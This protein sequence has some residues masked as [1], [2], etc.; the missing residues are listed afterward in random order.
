MFWRNY[1]RR[2]QADREWREEMEAH[3]EMAADTFLAQGMSTEE[4]RSAA[5]KQAGNLMARREEIYQMNG[6]RWLDTLSG[7]LRYALRG[8]RRQRAFTATALLTLALGIGA[9][10]AIFGVI[11]SILIRPLAYP[12]AEALVGVWHTAPGLQGLGGSIECTPSMYFTYREENRT[13][14][15]FGV[16]SSNGASVTGIAEPELPRALFVTYGVL[17][18][19]GVNP[20]LGRWFSQADDT[21]GSPDAVILTYGYWQRRF[22]G[23]KSIIGRALT[24]NSK[25]HTVIGVMPR[26]FRFGRDPELI[27]PQRFERAKVFLGDFS[28]QGIAR[29]KPG[30]TIAQANADQARMLGVWLNAWPPTPGFPLSLFQNAHVGP[31]IQPLKQEIVGDVGATLWVVMGTLFLVLLIACANVA[32][33]LLVRGESRQQ[34][35][36]IRAALGAGWRRI[37][38][39]ML[40]ESLTLGLIGGALGL[41]LAYAALRVLV[42]KGPATLPRLAEIGIDPLVFAFALGASLFSGVLFGVIPVFKYAGPRVA[43]ALRGVGRTFSQGRERHRARNLLVVV[44]V[45]FALVLL[46][47]SGLM[48][49][50]FQ[51]LRTVR[52]GFTHPEEIQILHSFAPQA[53]ANE[54]ERVMRMYQEIRDK[55]AAIPGV[56]SVALA[57]AAPLE[58]F[59]SP[60]NPIYAEDKP[61]ASG[62]L[63]PVRRFRM[64]A[65][66]FFK[67]MGTR[68][69]AGRDFTWTDLYEKRYVA[70]VS[71]NLAREVWGDPRA[72]LG[73]RIR[74]G[75]I[76]PWR[77]VVGV[78]QD[79][80]D[81]GMQ[82]KPPPMAYWPALMDGWLFGGE[83]GF[84]TGTGMFAI[85]SNRT[86]T[87]GFLDELRQTIWSV[88]GKQPVFLV[89]TLQEL[90][91][92]SMAR[93]SFT[94]VMLVLAGGM[95]LVLG[96]VGIYGVI[97]YAVSQRTRE[98]GIRTA[99]GAQPASLSRMFVRQGL[100]LAGVGAA[101]GLT[102]A[103]GL[104]RLMSSLLF[105]VTALDPVT[106]AAVSALLIAAAVIAS[107]LPARRAMAIDPVEALR[108]E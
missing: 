106:Y 23:D 99:L 89:S 3:I 50:T 55:L 32:N 64:T 7:D 1:L 31:K 45:A 19:I 11:D 16:W 76:D 6:I 93:T 22:G 62:Q 68:V 38:R 39:E 54:P 42:A 18:A 51:Q 102:A 81:N 58:S 75:T 65:P 33:L 43:T 108:A 72:A 9:N 41:G 101:L 66:G 105:G 79:V 46:V 70:M 85:R 48:I 2:N 12:H 80:Y 91:D 95:A 84:V 36:A 47:S 13:F 87:P 37:A 20:L 69:I 90:Y 107:Y 49:R 67:T 83:N 104:T 73:K 53:I 52:P 8:L 88:N 94:L 28:Y 14:Q 60:N 86:G 63:P 29:L 97:A 15:H 40:L 56:T 26:E 78:V 4:A 92:Q 24:I 98:I 5:L 25:P 17:D 34:E 61:F 57:N 44:Q 82:V 30:V 96:I 35:L 21:P 27:L 71:E 77:D 74:V 100:L 10:T 59:M 103:A